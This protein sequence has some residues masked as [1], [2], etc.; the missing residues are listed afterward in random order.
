MYTRTTFW[1]RWV[2][3][4]DLIRRGGGLSDLTIILKR[5]RAVLAMQ[6][7]GQG[8][9][10]TSGKSNMSRGCRCQCLYSRTWKSHTHGGPGRANTPASKHEMSFHPFTARSFGLHVCNGRAALAHSWT[11]G[12]GRV[13]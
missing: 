9:G 6:S 1:S 10:G 3:W 4:N 13:Y 5:Q 8:W 12:T 2:R 7:K 11:F